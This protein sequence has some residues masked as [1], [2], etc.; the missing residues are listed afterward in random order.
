MSPHS[1][2]RTGEFADSPKRGSLFFMAPEVLAG[3]AFGRASDIWSF[4]CCVIEMAT[5][6][7]PWSYLLDREKADPHYTVTS[8]V[9]STNYLIIK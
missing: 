6:K 1:G 7:P 5:G 3:D 2:T 4:G 9:S 8:I